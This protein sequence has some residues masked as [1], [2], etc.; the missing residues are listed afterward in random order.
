MSFPPSFLEEIRN[1]LPLS[2]VVGSRIRMTRA[3][4]EY[5]GCCPFHNEKTPSFY[6]NDDKQFYHCFGCGAHGDVIGFVMRHDRLSFPEA[7]ESLAAQAGL[8]V[9]RDTPIER[10]KYD[11]EKRLHLLLERATEWFETRLFEAGGKEGLAY[12]HA[13][14]LNDDAIRR[15]RLGYAP[16]DGQALIRHLSQKEIGGFT[17]QEMVA[18]GL[19]KKAEDRADHYSFFRN[20]VIFPVGDR[21]GRTVAF[22]GRVLGDGEPK[23][24]NSPDHELF[25]KGHLLY[26]LSRA[27]TAI[28]Q[29]QP[30]IVV[31]GYMDVIALV[32]AG[33]S[34]AVAP[35]GTA[36]TEDQMQVLWKMLPPLES[37]EATRD[38]S[39]ILCFDGDSA[40][41]R[42]AS[43]A[44]ERALP[45]ITSAQTLRI[46]TIEGAKDPDELIRK[47]GR[48]AF[49]A[50]LR[51]AQPLIDVLWALSIAGRTLK[52]P[53]ER[54]SFGVVLKKRVAR[55]KDEQLRELYYDEF[56]K[57][58][59]SL[60]APKPRTTNY[61]QTRAGA[62]PAAP[63][64]GAR[65]PPQGKRRAAEKILLALMINHPDLF[66][67]YGEKFAVS[68]FHTPE[69]ETLRKKTV[70]HLSQGYEEKP[71]AEEVRRALSGSDD[72]F[73]YEESGAALAE[74]LSASTYIGAGKAARPDATFE[75]A[76]EAWSAVWTSV[77]QEKVEAERLQRTKD[78]WTN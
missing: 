43:R 33:Y 2:G 1:R 27:R 64:L 16:N 55:I 53:E 9:P 45:N 35:L 38:Y 65:R 72:P 66:D 13:R 63:Y 58:I 71:T 21:R 11:T 31:E 34:G 76:S 56:K 40:G 19:A 26:G 7:I 60:F 17:P 30:I 32:E 6:V 41:I 61:R 37:R 5:K 29:G 3:G 42:A 62:G 48:S 14:G 69:F 10:E 44:V 28:S 52:T 49:D 20:R 67:A 8:Q 59:E 68:E 12:L 70:E 74:V 77:E 18:V 47:S 46:A 24:L 75:E 25:H 15:F 39:P 22:G 50:I 51:Q 78:A 23:Y 54:A 36:L 73:G 4:R 57:R